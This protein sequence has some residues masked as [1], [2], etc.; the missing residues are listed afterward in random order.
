MAE[1]FRLAQGRKRIRSHAGGVA[2]K[3]SK[4]RL[5]A[6]ETGRTADPEDQ[7]VEQ[8][9]LAVVLRGPPGAGKSTIA[10]RLLSRLGRD[11]R[12][13]VVLDV[14]WGPS[15]IRSNS[16]N[17]YPDLQTDEVNAQSVVFVEIG[18]AEPLY[19]LHGTGQFVLDLYPGATLNPKEWVSILKAQGRK[20]HSFFLWSEWETLEPRIRA[21]SDRSLPLDLQKTVHTLY[22][23]P[24]FSDHFAHHAEIAEDR[25]VTGGCTRDEVEAIV[26]RR[27]SELGFELKTEA[28]DSR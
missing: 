5:L 13:C 25:I 11:K 19:R 14:G 27:L 23:R 18:C 1:E 3:P 8:K 6:G 10:T 17:R 24:D 9:R 12:E 20:V 28:I 21:D 4:P 2:V 26:L 15:E 7:M 16:A 22:G